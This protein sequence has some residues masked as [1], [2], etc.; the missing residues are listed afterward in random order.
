MTFNKSLVATLISAAMCLP[1]MADTDGF[2]KRFYVGVAGGGSELEP[3]SQV[4]DFFVEDDTD[5]GVKVFLGY[6]FSPR[7]AAELAIADLGE[8][9]IGSVSAGTSV[10]AI[11]YEVVE[12]SGLYRFFDKDRRG[13]G[14]FVK[15]GVGAL[16]NDSELN[17][18][19]DNDVHLSGGVG[20]EWASKIGLALRGEFEAFDRDATL[21]TLGVLWRFGGGSSSSSSASDDDDG[22]F[23]QGVGAVGGLLGGADTELATLDDDDNDGVPNS[24]DDCAGTES[25]VPVSATGCP[26]F[27]GVLEGVQFESGSDQLVD[28]AQDVLND[29]AD[30]LLKDPNL[31]VEVQAHTDSQGSEAFNIELSKKRALAT[32]RYLMLRGVPS[33]QMTA[34]AFGES[35]PIAD[36]ATAAGRSTN[37]RVEFH[38]IER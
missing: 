34:R 5:T 36:N 7:F 12:L 13:F 1:A 24:L 4:P 16:D 26:V 30:V 33:E 28:A 15:L 25:G 29:A 23:S 11:S 27:G 18:T 14:A 20:V 10:G 6:D 3:E 21:A 19:R 8:A 38:V 17:F 32:V 37:R 31:K 2:S 9:V 22:L 35:K